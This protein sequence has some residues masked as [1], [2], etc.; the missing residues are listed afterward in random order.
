MS[1]GLA[2]IPPQ[3]WR[4]TFC[5][6]SCASS[7]NPDVTLAYIFHHRGIWSFF[8]LPSEWNGDIQRPSEI[9]MCPRCVDSINSHRSSSYEWASPHHQ[10]RNVQQDRW[11]KYGK[12]Q[13]KKKSNNSAHS[14]S[15]L[16]RLISGIVSPFFY[17]GNRSPI[18]TATPA[19]YRTR[20]PFR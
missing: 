16:A 9:K 17:P 5:V 8:C 15:A 10:R 4:L 13:N 12:K 7:L 2:L 20:S 6:I 14:A 11:I 19:W 1:Y 18:I 3:R